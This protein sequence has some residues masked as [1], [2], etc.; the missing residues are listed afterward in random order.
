MQQTLRLTPSL[1]N[2]LLLSTKYSSISSSRTSKD[3][4]IPRTQW[5]G[6]KKL[7]NKN[8]LQ[9]EV[10]KQPFFSTR[11]MTVYRSPEASARSCRLSEGV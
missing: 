8:D 6:Q 5:P 2:G 10:L 4:W 9:R 7:H 3:E 11:T 1:S